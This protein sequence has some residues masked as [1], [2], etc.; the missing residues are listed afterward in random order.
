MPG[1]QPQN[2]SSSWLRLRL[3]PSGWHSEVHQILQPGVAFPKWPLTCPT[4]SLSVK[5]GSHVC[6]QAQ[7]KQEHPDQSNWWNPTHLRKLEERPSTCLPQ[8]QQRRTVS[9]TTSFV[10]SWEPRRTVGRNHTPFHWRSTCPTVPTLALW[11]PCHADPIC[12]EPNYRRRELP[13]KCNWS[14]DGE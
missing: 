4:R 11:N 2:P 5:I 7:T 8:S 6:Y 3:W 10:S 13:T 1:S 12:P 9:L 14:W